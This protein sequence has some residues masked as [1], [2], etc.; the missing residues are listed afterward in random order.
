MRRFAPLTTGRPSALAACLTVVTAQAGHAQQPGKAYEPTWHHEGQAHYEKKEDR[1]GQ[2]TVVRTIE[3][4]RD[5]PMLDFGPWLTEQAILKWRDS[6][7]TIGFSFTDNGSSVKFE[8]ES[9]SADQKTTCIMQ[10]ALVGYDPKPSTIENWRK[11]QPFVGQQLHYCTAI[12]SVDLKR[13]LS[14]MQA[15]G[16]DYVSAANAWKSV[17]VELFGPGG[18][19]CV[20]DR[21]VKPITTP[22]RYEC[23]KYSNP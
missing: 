12:D 9:K 22:P 5:V 13:A 4:Y 8:A 18:R 15:S 19:R 7:G 23:A 1:F 14:Q 11:L 6:T 16:A 21:M 10:G 2:F 3:D 20:R 17:S